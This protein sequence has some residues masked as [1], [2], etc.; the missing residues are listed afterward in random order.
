[1]QTHPG[2][3]MKLIRLILRTILLVGGV[4]LV[5]A[6]VWAFLPPGATNAI[7]ILALM[8][9][10]TAIL[11]IAAVIFAA[12]VYWLLKNVAHFGRA[13]RV[14]LAIVTLGFVASFSLII[15]G[16]ITTDDTDCQRFNYNVKMNGGIKQVDGTTYIINICGSGAHSHGFFADQNEQV[17]L[18]VAD[19]HGSTL[20][21]RLFFVFWDG[22]PG[23]DSIKI[24]NG[25][26]IYFDAADEYDSERSIS[27]PPTT[28][29]WIAARIPIW[30]R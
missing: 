7:T 17:K 28:I 15:F 4:T 21:T 23:Q 10:K 13:K 24:R 14:G 19:A 30:L 29:D 8:N 1:M 12:Y 2:G 25:K 11:V 26:L 16:G 3:A 9:G 22:R 27:M 6:I 20:A 5:A 18:V